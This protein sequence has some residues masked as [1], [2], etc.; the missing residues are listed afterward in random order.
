MGMA[1]V[2]HKIAVNNV[3][4]AVQAMAWLCSA[5]VAKK[6]QSAVANRKA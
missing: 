2:T 5:H 3:M 1:S 6:S 4:V